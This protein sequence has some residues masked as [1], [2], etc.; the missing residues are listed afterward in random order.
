MTSGSVNTTELCQHGLTKMQDVLIFLAIFWT[1][2]VYHI[3]SLCHPVKN[4]NEVGVNSDAILF[5]ATMK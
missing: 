1:S 5:R 3:N 2:N 4:L